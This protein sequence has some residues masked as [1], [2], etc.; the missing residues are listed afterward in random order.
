MKIALIYTPRSGSTSIL[1]YFEKQKP[2]FKCYGEPW[3]EWMQKNHYKKS[4]S[5]EE[6]LENE[7]VFVKSA[8]KTLPVSLDTIKKDFD[9]VIFLLRR[10]IK[11]QVESNAILQ[12]KSDY[13][14][15]SKRGYNLNIVSEEDIQHIEDRIKY[16]NEILINYSIKN[17]IKV[18]YYED[19]FFKDFS[20]FFNELQLEYEK[21][22]FNEILNKDKKYRIEELPIK[23]KLLI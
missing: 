22:L 18:F 5:Y 13:L 20:P 21:E 6:V 10:D 2:N 7:N 8:Y 14:N 11:S 12:K 9:K 19:L 15:Y 17:N 3:F 1:R 4:I 16:T 23:Q